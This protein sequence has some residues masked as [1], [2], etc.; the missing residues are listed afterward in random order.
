MLRIGIDGYNLAMPHGTG[1]A[2]YGVEL[3][4]ALRGM[5]HSV[6]GLFGLKVPTETSLREV[7]FYDALQRPA[8][9]KKRQS[10]WIRR[11]EWVRA[12]APASALEVPMTTQV[13][14]LAFAQRMPVFDRL[15]TSD[16]LFE[17]AFQRFKVTGQFT[18]IKIDRP[19]D[20]MHWTYPVPIRVAGARNVYTLHDVVP[21]KL[22]YTTLDDKQLYGRILGK[23]I[24]D[25]AHLCT[26]SE[27]SKRDVIE[28]FGISEAR[29]TNSYQA[30]TAQPARTVEDNRRDANAVEGIFG[31]G[32]RG[33]FLYFGA[34]EPKKNVGR[35]IEAYLSLQSETP[36]VIVGARAWQSDEELK[37]MPGGGRD[38][39]TG[40]FAGHR[41]QTIMRL[42]Y[43]SR[44]MLAQLVRGARA[45]VF[46]SLYEGF[47]LPVLEAMQ[48]GTPVLS[49]NTSALPEVV[50]RAGLLVDP[51]DVR[52]ITEAMMRLDTDP[53]LRETMAASGLRRAELFSAD[54]YR[55]RLAI[56]YDRAMRA[57]P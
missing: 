22:P 5:G 45:V 10:R 7:A 40:T 14:K 12:L 34:I 38:G 20:I 15:M 6:E 33:Y 2:T 51:Y 57:Q 43:L 46:P 35:L 31:L 36:L 17:R 44:S 3:V 27:S 13:E 21:L 47:G 32:H 42:D 8:D 52:A 50:G 56:L 25:A 24:A 28:R 53:V 55:E 9:P 49:S 39:G 29:I 18:T 19:P 30:V 11:W 4:A 23:C 16:L 1:V 26:V 37:L 54:R 48:M 41:K